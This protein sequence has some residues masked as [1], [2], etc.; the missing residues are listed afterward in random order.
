MAPNPTRGEFSADANT[1]GV[2]EKLD[3]Y[4]YPSVF[5]YGDDGLAFLFHLAL[6]PP[7][8]AK[9]PFQFSDLHVPASDAPQE[10]RH[11]PADE[12]HHDAARSSMTPSLRPR[13]TAARCDSSP[14]PPFAGPFQTD[15][16]DILRGKIVSSRPLG[17]AES[18]LGKGVPSH[19]PGASAECLSFECLSGH[20]PSLSCAPSRFRVGVVWKLWFSWFVG[21]IFMH[22]RVFSQ[23]V[24]A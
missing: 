14:P 15:L 7:E 11:V 6:S 24:Y 2:R 3:L 13:S 23:P 21:N 22:I 4:V 8:L 5:R 16:I 17:N 1:S 9:L 10:P 19:F 20:N 18:A 12:V